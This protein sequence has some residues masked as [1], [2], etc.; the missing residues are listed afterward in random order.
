MALRED[1]LNEDDSPV[2]IDS[3]SGVWKRSSAHNPSRT[4]HDARNLVFA[5]QATL[6]WLDELCA[7]QGASV[8]VREGIEDLS[9]VSDRLNGLLTEALSTGAVESE[10]RGTRR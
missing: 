7:T 2:E 4:L 6:V 1:P 8:E 5:L 3:A 10:R 9:A